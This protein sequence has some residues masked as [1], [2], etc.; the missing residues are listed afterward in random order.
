MQKIIEE[1]FL[2]LVNL[3]K[4]YK[5]LFSNQ[6]NLNILN[7]TCGD[8][9]YTI[10]H[11]MN[12]DIILSLNRLLDPYYQGNN[13]N[14]VLE[15]LLNEVN[16]TTIKSKLEEMLQNIRNLQQ[17]TYN[18]KEIRNKRLAHSDKITR[19]R[20]NSFSTILTSHDSIEEIIKLISEFLNEINL[21]NGEIVKY[22]DLIKTS[23]CQNL[24][25]ALNIEN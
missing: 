6:D 11:S 16:D 13:K 9:F 24:I 17:D 23:S 25:D 4:E 2:Y 14:L 20:D 12:N 7:K 8:C 5:I 18:L 21:L 19:N 15:A 1:E 3:W 22:L 10:Q